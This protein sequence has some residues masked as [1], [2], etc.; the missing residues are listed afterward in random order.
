M[1]GR[2]LKFKTKEEL[3]K[4]IDEYFKNNCKTIPVKDEQGNVVV[5]K[6]GRPVFDINPPTVS[7]LA[8]YLGFES[9]QSMYDYKERDEFSYTIKET[10]LRIEEFAEKQLFVGNS[11]G[12]IFWLKNKGWRD[13]SEVDANIKGNIVITLEKE[14]AEQ[15]GIDPSTINNSEGQIQI[16]GD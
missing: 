6:K 11:V 2:P 5:D 13:K 4:L 1:I 3:Q 16:Q 9:R 8:R 10:T 14:I 15:N 12:A 7:G